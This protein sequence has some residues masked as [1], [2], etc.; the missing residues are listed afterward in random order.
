[1]SKV[2]NI[3][4]NFTAGELSPRLDGRADIKIYNNGC[5]TLENLCVW[6]HGGVFKRPGTRYIATV[7]DPTKETVLLPFVY[8][9]DNA[10]VIEMGDYYMRFYTDGGQ[11]QVSGVAY[12][13]ATPYPAAYVR[14]A[15]FVQNADVM[16]LVHPEIHPQKLIHYSTADWTIENVPFVNGPFQDEND[17]DTYLLSSSATAAGA[18]TVLT[19]SGGVEPF[20]STHVGSF[21]K[22]RGTHKKSRAITAENQFS[23]ELQFDSNEVVIIEVTGTWSATVVV[24]R[25]PDFGVNWLDY[26]TIIDN[27]S[28]AITELDDHIYYRIGVRTGDFVSGTVNVAIGKLNQY[29]YVKVTGYISPTQVSGTIIKELPVSSTYQWSEGSWSGA[30]GYPGAIAFYEERLIFANTWFQPQTVWGSVTDDY[31]NFEEDVGANDAYEFTLASDRVNN[32]N[33]MHSAN[34]ILHIGTI[35]GEWRFGDPNS[36]VTPTNV[37][38]TNET[39]YGSNKVSAMQVAHV[40]LF[41]Q[42]GGKKLRQRYYNYDTDGWVSPDISVLSEHLFAESGVVD[43]AYTD[44]P[45]PIVWLV[46]AD[47]KMIGLTIELEREISC[48]HKHSTQGYFE[49]VA[50]IPGDDRDELWTVVKRATSS[51]TYT[52]FVEQ[53]QTTQ[54]DE[55]QD[56]WYLD[57]AIPYDGDP[58]ATVSGLDHLNGLEVTLTVSGAVLPTETVSSGIVELDRAYPQIIAGL[59]YTATLSTMKLEAG[60]EFGTAQ[61]KRKKVLKVAVRLYKTLGVKIGSSS[62]DADIIPFRSSADSMGS[63]PEIFTG[64]KFVEFPKGYDRNISVYV[65]SDQPTPLHLLGVFPEIQTNDY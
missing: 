61:T 48:F 5:S 8:N 27:T 60:A 4:S 22:F 49:A 51:G 26:A 25:S 64:D 24:Q 34:K 42:R 47:G 7:K 44:Y 53:F 54:W 39:T 20:Y 46:R 55:I 56:S 9:E 43:M 41:V 58:S 50:S 59:P 10:Y 37:K 13:I 32:V 65:V 19:A 57:S 45:T 1:M 6:S 30:N 36:A 16:Y 18:S 11:V 38:V 52:R 2:T 3:Y 15:K 62:A 12:E 35:G 21:W 29:G 33:W 63:A 23:D 14:D 31:E 17:E 40:I 28:T